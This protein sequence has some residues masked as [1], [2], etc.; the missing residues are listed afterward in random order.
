MP[1]IIAKIEAE[2]EKQGQNSNLTYFFELNQ[3]NVPPMKTE[4]MQILI[5]W[6]KYMVCYWKNRVK[7]DFSNFRLKNKAKKPRYLG[8]FLPKQEV[9]SCL[10]WLAFAALKPQLMSTLTLPYLEK[11]PQNDGFFVEKN[12]QFFVAQFS[13]KFEV[14]TRKLVSLA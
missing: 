8:Y 5:L 2:H 12:A 6:W 1:S 9:T 7:A 13:A 11:Y 4:N 3:C 10:T 14:S